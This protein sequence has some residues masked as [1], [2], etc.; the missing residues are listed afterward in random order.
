[1][2]VKGMGVQVPPRTQTICLYSRV[3]GTSCGPRPRSAPGAGAVDHGYVSEMEGLAAAPGEGHSAIGRLQPTVHPVE[4]RLGTLN[5]QSEVGAER[6]MWDAWEAE[7][8]GD[9]P[10]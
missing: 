5:T 4:D 6:V 8:L 9:L 3:L 7:H 2:P 1:M 10:S